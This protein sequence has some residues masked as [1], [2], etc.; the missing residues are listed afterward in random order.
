V[1]GTT[2]EDRS[3][4]VVS[5]RSRVSAC[6]K[7][8][9]LRNSYIGHACPQHESRFMDIL[10]HNR[11]PVGEDA[12]EATVVE[13][14]ATGHPDA[15]AIGT[16]IGKDAMEATE[17]CENEGR[18]LVAMKPRK[19][20]RG[21]RA[22]QRVVSMVEARPGKEEGRKTGGMTVVWW[23]RDGDE[24]TVEEEY[25]RIGALLPDRTKFVLAR[26]VGEKR[27]EAVV[28][29]CGT[30]VTEVDVVRQLRA[31]GESSA[32]YSRVHYTDERSMEDIELCVSDGEAYA[33]SLC[34][35]HRGEWS[36]C[37]P[38]GS[39]RR[40]WEGLKEEADNVVV[41]DGSWWLSRHE[42]EET[43]LNG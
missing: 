43:E 23:R 26:A 17:G 10:V 5:A 4:L 7:R 11:D 34:V 28:L 21:L 14:N 19:R 27:C 6:N 16:R 15:P 18:T 32:V 37:G 30:R 40:S 29:L 13:Y 42:D 2:N 12:P 9:T 38:A 36:V 35:L 41:D 39:A 22:V 25:A 3:V 33:T 31:E 24:R 8:R 20:G 1:A